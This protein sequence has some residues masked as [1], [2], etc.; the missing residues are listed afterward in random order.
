MPTNLIS[1]F[2]TKANFVLN[3]TINQQLSVN[4]LNVKMQTC[5]CITFSDLQSF[6][7]FNRC[8]PFIRNG[9]HHHLH[10]STNF[11]LNPKTHFTTHYKKE[12]G[13]NYLFHNL[14]KTLN[15]NQ[16]IENLNLTRV[17][18]SYGH[19]LSTTNL[20]PNL[21]SSMN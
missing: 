9:N 15:P 7:L 1:N 21:S 3:L 5:R 2:E 11:S 13:V 18:L 19:F 10:S 16:C 8:P 17:Q 14:M 20:Q 12:K 4:L 6:T